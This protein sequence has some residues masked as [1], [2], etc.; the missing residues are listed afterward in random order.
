MIGFFRK[1]RKKL[2]DDNKPAKYF[3]YAIGEI[4]LVVIGILIALQVNTWNEERNEREKEL[5][6]LTAL[7]KEITENQIKLGEAIIQ[8][9]KMANLSKELSEI[10]KPNPKKISSSKFNQL[11]VSVIYPPKYEPSLGVV[12]GIISSGDLSLI[13]NIELK[14]LL[15]SLTGQLDIYDYW[16][17]ITYDK[18]VQIDYPFIIKRYPLKNLP[19]EGIELK[20]G[21]SKYEANQKS[22][23]ES[24]EF[25][26][27]VDLRHVNAVNLYT[28]AVDIEELQGKLLLLIDK[29]LN[30]I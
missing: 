18:H 23:I 24:F 7:E 6:I 4:L 17:G 28:L 22:L 8:H 29:E 16:A 15:S 5:K 1:I 12:N 9:Q 21:R 25:E 11:L 3:R 10:I 26:S 30:E 20:E 19:F 14:Y 2:A 27:M 13:T